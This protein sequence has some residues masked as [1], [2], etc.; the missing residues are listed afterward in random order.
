MN[1]TNSNKINQNTKKILK[2]TILEEIKEII[3]IMP[4]QHILHHISPNTINNNMW[5]ITEINFDKI[6]RNRNTLIYCYDKYNNKFI[7]SFFH[8]TFTIPQIVK[9]KKIFIK[10]YVVKFKNNNYISHP[11]TIPKKKSNNLSDNTTKLLPK[12]NTN[13]KHNQ[14][15]KILE[16]L[17]SIETI[18]QNNNVIDPCKHLRLIIQL[19]K[20]IHFPENYHKYQDSLNT[21]ANIEIASY[22]FLQ[23]QNSNHI[24][25]TQPK[26]NKLAQQEILDKLKIKLTPSQ[27]Q[28]LLEIE[29]N[30]QRILQGDVGS[31][32]TIIA[33]LSMINFTSQK[34]QTA[35][36]CP[37]TILAEQHYTFFQTTLKNLQ[38]LANI[39]IILLTSKVKNKK[40]IHKK[41]ALGEYD[42][43]I[44]THAALET[45]YK[46]LQYIVIDEQ[47]RFGV[48]Q[49][50]QLNNN[51]KQLQTLV[52]TA[53][54]IPRTLYLAL[55]Q[56]IPISH[57]TDKINQMQNIT[58]TI[59][60]HANAPSIIHKLQ[61]FISRNET[62]FW[63]C[64]LIKKSEN[65]T[66]IM[67]VE[68]RFESLKKI[69]NNRVGILHGQTKDKHII[70]QQLLK[71]E[72]NI[73]VAT[74]VVEVGIHIPHATCII[75][76]N[77]E[78]F[79][80]ATLHQ[81]RGR[82]G[83]SHLK[84][85]CLLIYNDTNNVYSQPPSVSD[86]NYNN[87]STKNHTISKVKTIQS[88]L[89]SQN[90]T[91]ASKQQDILNN[92]TNSRAYNR[93][94]ILKNSQCGLEIAKHDLKTRGQGNIFGYEQSGTIQ[95]FIFFKEYH[96]LNKMNEFNCCIKE[97]HH[98]F[99]EFPIEKSI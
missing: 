28:S 32:K 14:S 97:I 68:E 37:T 78:N 91:N 2:N 56:N 72:I 63:I 94:L 48:T 81:L 87:L 27:E 90:N 67:N 23:A 84:S 55:F 52:M 83:R 82:V 69:Y 4:K 95:N 71:K 89:Q 40:Q 42:I 66:S 18:L 26:P 8:K 24:L 16:S 35:L 77:A 49:R 3:K 96:V 44:G 30:Y 38:S 85:Y 60:S 39:N 65:N 5:I 80:L 43:I 12:Y 20:N 79:G 41:I 22:K 99:T 74:T 6:I 47:H 70:M 61:Y 54:P 57:I 19:L 59:H 29:S 36:I 10:G 53:T 1:N 21:L 45:Q 7:L 15:E 73:L 33:L 51:N 17:T 9:I 13:T 46:N 11:I 58:T 88:T 64:P 25:K 92:T 98:L 31:G 93:L 50:F 76:E 75:I 34:I 86:N 62:I